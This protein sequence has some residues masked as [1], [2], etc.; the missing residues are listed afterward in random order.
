VVSSQRYAVAGHF[1]G[2][3][4]AQTC[5]HSLWGKDYS[6]GILRI[7][8]GAVAKSNLLGGKKRVT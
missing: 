2:S 5:T 1:T 7:T 6:K 3:Y 8:S 4:V